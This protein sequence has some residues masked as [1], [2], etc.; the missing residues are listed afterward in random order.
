MQRPSYGGQATSPMHPW[1]VT[2]ADRRPRGRPRHAVARRAGVAGEKETTWS[3][4]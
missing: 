1:A 4:M 3:S 2:A